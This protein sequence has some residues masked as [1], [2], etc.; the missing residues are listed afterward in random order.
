MKKSSVIYAM[1]TTMTCVVYTGSGIA[2]LLHFRYVTEAMAHLGYPPFFMTLLGAW[3]L[4]GAIIVVAPR[5]PRLKEWAYA[6]MLVDLVSASASRA[7][8]G[9]GPAMVIVPLLILCAVLAS[10]ALR[11]PSRRL[12]PAPR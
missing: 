5:L 11:P 4:L 8:A 12:V 10:W 6:G 2:N 9:D 7:H 3:K 1:T